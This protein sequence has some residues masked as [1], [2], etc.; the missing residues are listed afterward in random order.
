[1]SLFVER[2]S[3]YDILELSRDASVEAIAHKFKMLGSRYHPMKNP[4]DMQTAA[5]KFAEVCEAYDVLSNSKESLL[6]RA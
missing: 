2:R 1:M 5:A 4:T 6:D 3:Y